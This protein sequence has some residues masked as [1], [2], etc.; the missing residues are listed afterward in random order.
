LH[1]RLRRE[2]AAPEERRLRL[3][4]AEAAAP[5]LTLARARTP[6]EAGARAAAGAAPAMVEAILEVV[7]QLAMEGKE[8]EREEMPIGRTRNGATVVASATEATAVASARLN[9]VVTEPAWIRGGVERAAAKGAYALLVVW[10]VVGR[11]GW[12]CAR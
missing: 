8:A 1:Q 12:V 4:S 7:C 11:C 2:E 6:R 9:A 10:V 3:R 5:R